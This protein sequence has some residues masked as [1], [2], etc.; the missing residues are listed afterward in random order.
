M[1]KDKYIS[2]N[3]EFLTALFGDVITLSTQ[4]IGDGDQDG[5]DFPA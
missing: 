3:A 5:F 2:P 1:K 4:S